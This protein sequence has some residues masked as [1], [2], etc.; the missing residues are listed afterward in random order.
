MIFLLI[1]DRE[2]QE[3]FSLLESKGI[4]VKKSRILVGDILIGE[5]AIERKERDDLESSIVDG[6]LFR[7]LSVLLDS[8]DKVILIIEGT[9][10]FERINRNA[11]IASLSSFLVRGVSIFF[12]RNIEETSELL[13]WI[14][15]KLKNNNNEKP[16]ISLKPKNTED[17]ILFILESLPGISTKTAKNM[18]QEFESL[19]DIANSDIEELTK[20][21]G[22]GKE[23]AKKI[24]E[25]LNLSFKKLRDSE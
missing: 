4:K 22:I 23:K 18:I 19:R 21:K 24:V 8:Y 7:Q 10:K 1:D 11:L 15:K 6:R 13:Y 16:L 12:T 14:D 5:I 17:F 25:V 2:P 20:V 9:K 3:L